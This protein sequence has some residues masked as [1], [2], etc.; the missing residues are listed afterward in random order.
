MCASLSEIS[1]GLPTCQHHVFFVS[2]SV[3]LSVWLSVRLL[4]VN[5]SGHGVA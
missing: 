1:W 3:I 4:D 2:Q 5:A